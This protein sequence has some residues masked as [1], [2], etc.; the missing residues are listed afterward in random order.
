VFS[1]GLDLDWLISDYYPVPINTNQLQSWYQNEYST[2]RYVTRCLLVIVIVAKIVV[3]GLVLRSSTVGTQILSM[4][5]SKVRV[6]FPVATTG[7]MTTKEIKDMLNARV[8]SL[9]WLELLGSM[10]MLIL[11]VYAHARLPW[12]PQFLLAPTFAS[13]SNLL[14]AKAASGVVLVAAILKNCTRPSVASTNETP[15]I[16]ILIDQSF[17]RFNGTLKFFETCLGILLWINLGYAWNLGGSNT[18]KEVK[19]VLICL[20]IAMVLTDCVAGALWITICW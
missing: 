4:A 5:W 19:I 3:L 2:V 1:V 10:T 8:L 18:P 13:F 9:I 20:S 6:F 12:A 14:Y 17:L 7:G 16:K 11:G 15:A